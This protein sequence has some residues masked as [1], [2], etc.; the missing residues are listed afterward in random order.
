MCFFYYFSYEIVFLYRY[1]LQPNKNNEK[2]NSSY[3]DDTLQS[4]LR[5][6]IHYTVDHVFPSQKY[7]ELRRLILQSSTVQ[8]RILFI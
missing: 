3:V 1:F 7:N 2:I 5:L 6:K 4:S 8:V